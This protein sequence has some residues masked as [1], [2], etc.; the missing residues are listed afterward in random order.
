MDA[1]PGKKASLQPFG[2]PGSAKRV[3]LGKARMDFYD[4]AKAREDAAARAQFGLDP[5]GKETSEDVLGMKIGRLP[6]GGA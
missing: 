1:R 5:D 2:L 3:H 6:E 4:A